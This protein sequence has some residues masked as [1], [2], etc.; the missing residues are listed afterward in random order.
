MRRSAVVRGGDGRGEQ[1]DGRVGEYD[2]GAGPL[3]EVQGQPGVLVVAGVVGQSIQLLSVIASGGWP[4]VPPWHRPPPA[5]TARPPRLPFTLRGFDRQEFL[6]RM[7]GA[8]AKPGDR[9]TADAVDMARSSPG[10]V[11]YKISRSHGDAAHEPPRHP[12]GERDPW[13]RPLDESVVLVIKTW[14]YAG[15]GYT[16]APGRGAGR[17]MGCP[18]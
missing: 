18:R 4:D 1:P 13:G 10:P 5:A 11:M 15:T 3:G 16:A 14:T 8:G 2:A 17:R 9:S 6:M 7:A 12:G